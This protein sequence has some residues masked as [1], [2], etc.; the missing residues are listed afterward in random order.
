MR[1]IGFAFLFGFLQWNDGGEAAGRQG[2]DAYQRKQ[3]TQA[4]RFYQ[5]G[6]KKI[7]SGGGHTASALKNNLGASYFRQKR[8]QEAAQAFE[9]AA[10]YAQ[11]AV[12]LSRAYYNAG[13]TALQ[14]Q[15]TDAALSFWRKAL[16]AHPQN[17]AAR[18]NYELLR[19]L[20]QQQENTPQQNQQNQQNQSSNNQNQGQN[21]QQPPK[22][23]DDKNQKQQQNNGAGQQNRPENQPSQSQKPKT[24]KEQKEQKSQKQ[25]QQAQADGT[26]N[27]PR[28][29]IQQN[30]AQQI[31]N[32]QS[33][34]ERDLLHQV[35]R[36]PYR[37]RVVEQDW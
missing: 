17:E 16:L 22:P 21:Q 18:H 9:Q 5:D 31:L 37:E 28:P 1:W 14:T 2:N 29:L 33:A 20:M 23:K 32:A 26:P 12:D 3:Y 10:V 34:D 30:E 8:Y 15:Q 27:R 6:L 24:P 35:R 4:E 11:D 19:R 25:E 13:N 36:R 7:A